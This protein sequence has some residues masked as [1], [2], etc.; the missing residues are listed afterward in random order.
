MSRNRLPLD[1]QKGNLTVLQQEKRRNEEKIAKCSDDQLENVPA[2]VTEPIA[3]IEYRRL[4]KE[5]KK[6]DHSIIGN[7]DKDNL[8]AF[9]NAYAGYRKA[10]EQLSKEPLILQKETKFGSVSYKNPLIEIQTN[11]ANEMRKFAALCGLTIDSRLKA[12]AVKTT[13][14]EDGIKDKFGAI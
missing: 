5:L 1:Q 4:I 10:T 14:Q 2:W 6:M 12:A 3:R 9:C 8:G 7:L 13:K 11:Y